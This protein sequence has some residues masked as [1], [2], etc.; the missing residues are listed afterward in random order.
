MQDRLTAI[1]L[2]LQKYAFVPGLKAVMARH[3]GHRGW[4]NM[5]PPLVQLKA[6]A[7]QALFQA[8]DAFSLKLAK[9]A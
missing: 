5:R 1:R 9:A 3:T 4:T 8:L 7:Q 6:E 2:V